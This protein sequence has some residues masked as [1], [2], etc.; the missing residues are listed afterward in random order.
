MDTCCSWTRWTPIGSWADCKHSCCL[1]TDTKYTYS[2]LQ[3]ITTG[4][5][6][7][8]QSILS[9]NELGIISVCLTDYL[10]HGF[11]SCAWNMYFKINLYPPLGLC[12]HVHIYVNCL[13]DYWCDSLLGA[14]I[15]F[16]SIQILLDFTKPCKIS[17]YYTLWRSSRML[18]VL[19]LITWA[20][21]APAAT[22][23]TIATTTTMI[24]MINTESP[25]SQ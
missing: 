4:C 11:S 12:C 23:A 5:L 16:A 13:G 6:S 15:G 2:W 19:K 18:I 3:T 22:Q 17:R 9:Q 10:F 14:C 7:N 20:L 21:E 8:S 1:E 24:I 25:Q